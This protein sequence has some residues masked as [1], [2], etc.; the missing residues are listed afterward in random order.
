LA[1]A[2]VIARSA[3]SQTKTPDLVGRLEQLLGIAVGGQSRIE[4][5][6]NCYRRAQTADPRLTD[7]EHR[8]ASLL[9]DL[10][11]FDEARD[12]FQKILAREPLNLAAHRDYDDF[13]HCTGP[14]DEFLRSYDRA[15]SVVHNPAPLL[16][17]KASFL[18]FLHRLEEAHD[19]Y[20]RV[21]IADGGNLDAQIGK[22]LSLSHM[23][24]FAPALQMLQDLVQRHP[25]RANLHGD[26]ALIRLRMGDAKRAVSIAE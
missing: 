7:L 16:M 9:V 22:A 19:L 24:H 1:E 3:L 2:E 11:R 13:L 15:A 17:A 6:I 26:I 14:D 10:V 25:E 8:R 21:H 12:L 5:E 4:E 23:N 20:E 18:M